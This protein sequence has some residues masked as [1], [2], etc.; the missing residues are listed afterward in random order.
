[1]KKSLRIISALAVASLASVAFAT[2]TA[3]QTATS[4]L[5]NSGTLHNSIHTR[6]SAGPGNGTSFSG[7][8][9]WGSVVANGTATT[10]I[11]PVCGGTC[12]AKSGEVKV[13]G[14]VKT[15]IGGNAFNTSTGS[16]DGFASASGKVT[17]MIDVKA[18]YK[19]P[20]QDVNVY[21]KADQSADFTV[22]A[23]KNQ[24]GFAVAGSEANFDVQ[25]AVGSRTCTSVNDCGGKIVNKEVWGSVSDNKT[26]TSWAQTGALTV[27][28]KL[29]N[30]A[31]ITNSGAV[32]NVTAGGKFYDPI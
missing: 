23:L 12:P 32:S 9:S 21:G 17:G 18:Q 11:N 25:G 10:A 19:G 7:A 8:S 28:G 14:E 22:Q 4:S 26:S 24:G 30:P 13:T 29:T 16:G 15:E 3:T 1:M 6:A 27:D 2:G 31:N 5:V 20:G